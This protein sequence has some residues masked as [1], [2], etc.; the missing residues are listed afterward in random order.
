M[1]TVIVGYVNGIQRFPS[2]T[3]KTWSF[4]AGSGSPQ[5]SRLLVMQQT[6]VAVIMGRRL[7]RDHVLFTPVVTATSQAEVC[8]AGSRAEVKVD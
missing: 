1:N 5:L 6:W 7:E 8:V 3:A 4:I 2:N